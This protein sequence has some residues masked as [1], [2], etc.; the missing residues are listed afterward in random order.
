VV[1]RNAALFWHGHCGPLD[2]NYGQNGTV[3]IT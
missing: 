1:V 3:E 2:V